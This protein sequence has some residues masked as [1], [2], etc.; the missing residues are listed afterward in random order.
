MLAGY[1]THCSPCLNVGGIIGAVVFA[2]VPC[3]LQ[4]SKCLTIYFPISLYRR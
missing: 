4:T 1:F 3:Q 2:I